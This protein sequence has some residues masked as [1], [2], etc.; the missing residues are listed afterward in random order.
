MDRAPT[1]GRTRLTAVIVACALFMQNL[2]GTVI[3]TALPTMARAFHADPVSMNVALTAYLLAVTLFIPASGWMADRFGARTIFRAAIA[4]FTIG[5]VLCGR[6]D[7]LAFLVGAR[8]VQGV[9]G[10][11]MVPVGRLVLLRAAPKSELLSAMAWLTM[12]A[13]IGPVLGPL[14][15]GL[16]VT[17]ADWRWIFD[18]NVPIGVLGIV[19]VT[20]FV[21]D[22]RDESPGRFDT[23]G[24]LLVGVAL[25]GLTFGVESAGRSLLP[26]PITASL[27]VAGTTAALGYA[28]PRAPP[29]AS[30]ARSVTDARADVC[31]VD[32]RRHRLSRRR[33]RDPLPAAADVPGRVWRHGRPKRRDHVR[34]RG[35]R[36]RHQAADATPSSAASAS[37]R[38][39]C[40]SA[41]SPPLVWRRWR[42]SARGGRCRRS[43]PFS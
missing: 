29:R 36:F 23:R 15:G 31:R 25:V 2:D 38:P 39:W 4:V 40:G 33:R 8:I 35:W 16:I 21:D 3:A 26:V 11:M 24:F 41:W 6:A 13:M 18:I 37:G 20:A 19:L 27:L 10:A 28:A 30:R 17:Y 22:V 34:Q 43:T 1:S 14:V 12:P 7:T 5:S 9:G 42:R 32:H